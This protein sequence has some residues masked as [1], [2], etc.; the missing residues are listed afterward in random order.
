MEARRYRWRR[1][2]STDV[3]GMRRGE[4]GDKDEEGGGETANQIGT[5]NMEHHGITH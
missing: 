4:Q 2:N 1:W 5:K 3:V